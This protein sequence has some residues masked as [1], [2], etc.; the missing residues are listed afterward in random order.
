MKGCIFVAGI[1]AKIGNDAVRGLASL[2][3]LAK[4]LLVRTG[5]KLRYALALLTNIIQGWKGLP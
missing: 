3:G 5:A 1:E 4:S 2:S